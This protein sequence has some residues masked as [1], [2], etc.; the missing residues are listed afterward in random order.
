M[1]GVRSGDLAGRS[2]TGASAQSGLKRWTD[3]M[4]GRLDHLCPLV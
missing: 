4:E 2:P 3:D 1:G